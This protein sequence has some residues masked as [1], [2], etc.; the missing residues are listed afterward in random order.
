[1][2]KRVIF[3]IDYTLLK[4]NYDEEHTFFSKINMNDYFLNHIGEVLDYYEKTHIHYEVNDFLKYLSHYSKT[5]LDEEFLKSWFQFNTELKE[6]DVSEA[7]EILE[8]LRQQK[9]EIVAL[10]NLFT[11]AQRKKLEKVG[12][13]QYFDEVY[14]GDIYLKPYIESYLT[15]IGYCAPNECLMIGDNLQV[16]VIAPSNLGI[17]GIHYTQ[18]E[19]NHEYPKIKKLTEIKKYF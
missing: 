14:G 8:Y 3:D 5:P 7:V 16:D 11:T 15:A 10:S 18:S 12:L 9:V 17:H 6:Q 2:I 1:M 13:I 4:P 19:S